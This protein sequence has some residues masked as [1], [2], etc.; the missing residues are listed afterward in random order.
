MDISASRLPIPACLVALMLPQSGCLLP[1]GPGFCLDGM[2]EITEPNPEVRLPVDEAPHCWTGFE[3]WYY[4]GRVETLEAPA[5][6]FG[7]HTVIFHVPPYPLALGHDFWF[8][9][10][11]IV[12]ADTG[13]F[14][15]DQRRITGGQPE[16]LPDVGFDINGGLIQ[17]RGAEGNDSIT[18]TMSDGRFALEVAL[19]DERGAVL[20]G[21]DGYVR[22]GLRGS[23]FYYSRPHMNGTGT[24]VLDGQLVPIAGQFWFDRQW[25]LNV[26]GSLTPWRWF[27]I[28]LDDGTAVMLFT[29]GPD[30]EVAHGTFIPAQGDAL[31]LTAEDFDILPTT[32]WTSPATGITYGTTWNLA[33]PAENLTLIVTAVTDDQEL[34]VRPTT[35]NLYWEGLCHVTGTRAADPVTGHAF[36]EQANLGQP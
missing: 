28:R 29:F 2:Y 33:V 12:N 26:V 1:I 5:R 34:D 21:G 8:A 22:H 15:Y 32:T 24:L 27:S 35:A 23:S 19:S 13:E 16:P 9:H 18:A 17:M 7:L 10:Y 30:A 36:I 11:A 31:P 3:W 25:G 20:H 14:I 6:V 4:T